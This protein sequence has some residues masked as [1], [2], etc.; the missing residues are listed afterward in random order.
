MSDKKICPHCLQPYGGLPNVEYMPEAQDTG[1]PTMDAVERAAA[2]LK[3]AGDPGISVT[4]D[5]V[6]LFSPKQATQAQATGVAAN[7][8][9]TTPLEGE[10]SH[11]EPFRNSL[12]GDKWTICTYL[13]SQQL[14]E[15]HQ[16]LF[17]SIEDTLPP[18]SY[19]LRV[20][21]YDIGPKI[22]KRVANWVSDG[23]IEKMMTTDAEMGVYA[24]LRHLW[25][26]E[27]KIDT[28][29]T[30][31]MADDCRIMTRDWYKS[32]AYSILRYFEKGA[33]IFGKPFVFELQPT[34]IEWVKSRKWF[35]NR[36]FQLDDGTEAPNGNKVIFPEAPFF[37]IHTP[38]IY[39]ADIPDPMIY[40]AGGDYMLMEQVWQ[41]GYSL[42]S[43]NSESEHIVFKTANRP[44]PP[45][46]HVGMPE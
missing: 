20:A 33:R 8:R 3:Q 31:W 1:L 14:E 42:Q 17:T 35:R 9:V 4:E 43:W 13:R 29:W 26:D 10:L 27:P 5:F 21:A 25:H 30:I 40:G 19:V 37:A 15:T 45:G 22:S 16:N 6:D 24:V 28:N 32:L 23:R 38:L 41:A 34:Q 12:I 36:H 46:A 39:K 44:D 18:G 11:F 7:L 2:K